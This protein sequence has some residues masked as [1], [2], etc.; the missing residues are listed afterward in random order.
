MCGILVVVHIIF[1]SKFKSRIYGIRIFGCRVAR[2]ISW[3]PAA[4]IDNIRRYISP[5]SAAE[6]M[7]QYTV[8][9]ERRFTGS[10][11]MDTCVKPLPIGRNTHT[12][13]E[14]R[15]VGVSYSH[16]VII[17]YHSITVHILVFDISRF[18]ASP[19]I[20][21][22]TVSYVVPVLEQSESNQSSWLAYT[23]TCFIQIRI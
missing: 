8:D 11:E 14:T 5:S 20:L 19:S 13:N 7:H 18:N 3:N 23:E 10:L 12:I 9:E 1:S 16:A 21:C 2:N 22:R 4:W 17:V 15:S 6:R